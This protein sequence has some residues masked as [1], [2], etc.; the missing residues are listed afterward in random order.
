[1]WWHDGWGWGTWLAMV[2]GNVMWWGLLFWAA[3]AMMR[4]NP[5][6]RARTNPEQ[7]VAVRFAAGEI[8]EEE[9][10]RR[11]AALHAA[12]VGV[13]DGLRSQK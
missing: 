11:L 8:E 9:Y 2:A 13:D 7:V 4:G 10:R 3:A 5:S 6:E 12:R 1:M